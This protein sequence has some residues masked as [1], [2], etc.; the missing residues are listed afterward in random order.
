MKIAM[1]LMVIALGILFLAV[2]SAPFW[3]DVNDIDFSHFE[4]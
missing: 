2:V 4:Q 1:T 3:A